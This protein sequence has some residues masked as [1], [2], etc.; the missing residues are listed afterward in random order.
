MFVADTTDDLSAPLGQ[1]SAQK[2]RFRVPFNPLQVLAV[3]LGLFLTIFLGFALFGN[4][5]FGGEPIARVAIGPS[6]PEEKSAAAPMAGPK[7]SADHAP[8]SAG[9]KTITI[10]DGS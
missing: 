8:A 4:N 3:L 10:I 5:P 9:Q 1:K 6:G 7:P 2:R